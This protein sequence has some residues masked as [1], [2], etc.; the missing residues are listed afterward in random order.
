LEKENKKLTYAGTQK[1]G[2]RMS[3][4]NTIEE[5][6]GSSEGQKALEKS[7]QAADEVV[8]ELRKA[9]FVDREILERPFGPADGGRVWPHQR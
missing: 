2:V 1:G 6:L 7:R 9:R 3:N 4:K 8:A 5:W